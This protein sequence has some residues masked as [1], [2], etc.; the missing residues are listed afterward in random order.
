VGVTI[1]A[2]V[3]PPTMVEGSDARVTV[4]VSGQTGYPDA[5]ETVSLEAVSFDILPSQPTALDLSKGFARIEYVVTPK[6]HGTKYLVVNAHFGGPEDKSFDNETSETI[7]IRVL[8]SG[9]SFLGI[10]SATW[11]VLQVIGSVSGFPSLL[12]LIVTRILDARKK[13]AEDK[14]A[15][16]APK[17]ILPK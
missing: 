10:T 15:A 9:P 11:T 17:I 4:T 3:D 13:K 8:S 16:D 1:E 5:R 6:G 12:I 7:E 2:K 14:Q